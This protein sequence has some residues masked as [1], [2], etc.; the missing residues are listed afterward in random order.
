MGVD[1]GVSVDVIVGRPVLEIIFF[2]LQADK[3][4][5]LSCCKNKP[6]LSKDPLLFLV[7][8]DVIFLLGNHSTLFFLP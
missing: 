2:F 8:F 7:I 1:I 4:S 6:T 3:I 5:Y